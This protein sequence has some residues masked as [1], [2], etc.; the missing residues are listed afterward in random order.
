MAVGRRRAVSAVL[1]CLVALACAPGTASARDAIVTSFD[2]TLIGV[3]LFAPTTPPP[4]GRAPTVLVGATYPSPGETRAD[5]DVGDRIGIATLRRAGYNVVT[6]DPRGIGGSS[7]SVMFGSPAFEGRDAR[8]VLDWLGAQAEAQLD[9]PGD[10]RVGMSGTS[11]G[12]AIQYVLAAIDPRVDAIVPDIGWHSLVTSLARGRAVKTGWL[13]PLCG[14]DAVA[15]AVEGR[16][17]A[18][19]VRP[20]STSP[21]LKEACV[22]GV[23]GGLS[24]A[25]RKWL[26]DRGPGALVRQVRA[27][28]LIT[29]GTPDTLFPL[30]E[31][32]ANYD[33]LRASGTPVKMIWYCGGHVPCPTEASDPGRLSRAGLA[34]FDRWLR[35]NPAVDTGPAFEWVADDGMWRAGPDFPLASS[36]A[37]DAIGSGSL[38]VAPRYSPARGLGRVA[39][40]A[41]N[42]VEA[43]FPPPPAEADVLGTPRVRLVY[44]GRARPARTHL[45]AQIVDGEAEDVVGGQA[46]PLPV[47]LDGRERTVQR[48]LEAIA[49]RGRPSSSY[50]LQITAG[51]ATYE[52]QRSRGRVSVY[53]AVG[54]LPLVDATRSGRGFEPRTPRRP[55]IGLRA[56]REGTRM[57][58]RLAVA[59]R[60]RPCSGSVTFVV[61]TAR[62]PYVYNAPLKADSCRATRVVKLRLRPGSRVRVAATFN[63]NPELKPRRAREV[64]RRVAEGRL[65]RP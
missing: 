29:Q 4:G 16:A 10:P 49:V 12:A 13:A 3:H 43:L 2:G 6:W 59:L 61:R 50:R 25:S 32:I 64:V 54:A 1:A 58:I 46:T 56:R 35:G 15:G 30:N 5:E 45:Y 33:A 23:A 19:D 28:T 39:G 7:G 20:A 47:I 42:S 41:R 9:A 14:L 37:L 40:P 60:T 17:R 21:E 55:R 62:R 38:K 34:W 24:R 51:A 11:Y 65:R 52:L 48:P 22:E 53:G 44:R 27:P 36:G 26:A 8:A 18:A 63:G 31:A 57:R